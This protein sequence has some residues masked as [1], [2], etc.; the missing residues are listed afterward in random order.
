MRVVP[1]KRNYAF[2][3]EG[4]PHGDQWVLK[5]RGRGCEGG[6][7]ARKHFFRLALAVPVALAQA[8][9]DAALRPLP[10]PAPASCQVRY[11]ASEPVLPTGLKGENFRWEVHG[12]P[13]EPGGA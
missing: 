9:A 8:P 5:V 11:P 7:R 4:I 12:G 10:P 1:V 6:P 13:G 2:E 3:E